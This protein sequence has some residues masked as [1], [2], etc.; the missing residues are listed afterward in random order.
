MA[1]IEITIHTDD[2]DEAARIMSALAGAVNTVAAPTARP[3]DIARTVAEIAAAHIPAPQPHVPQAQGADADVRGVPYHPDHHAATKGK[4]KDGSWMRK[5][6]SD[7]DTV[8]R[9]EMQFVGRPQAPA[10]PVQAP[11]PVQPPAPPVLTVEQQ[12][13]PQPVQPQI[14]YIDYNTFYA[15]YGELVEQGWLT[16][17]R[18][19]E[20][21]TLSGAGTANDFYGEEPEKIAKRS[22]A[23][24][25]FK[26]MRA[27]ASA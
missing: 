16:Q 10:A 20:I 22:I 26:K 11:Q 7:K 17:D 6:G 8:T 5:K 23:W 14:E 4:N 25:E 27:L 19:V 21:M 1:K 15:T 2:N 9:Y 13:T 18:V 3:A 12:F 24:S